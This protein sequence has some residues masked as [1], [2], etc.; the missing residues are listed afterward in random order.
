MTDADKQAAADNLKSACALMNKAI[1]NVYRAGLH[2]QIEV[3]PEV[4][5]Q[6]FN[7][8]DRTVLQPLT[9]EVRITQ[10]L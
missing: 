2:A 8:V 4:M 1:E 9:L 10:Q 6:E 3:H 7:T 5:T